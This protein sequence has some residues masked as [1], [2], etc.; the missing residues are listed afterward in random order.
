MKL[1]ILAGPQ[2][3]GKM[4]IGQELANITELK[5]FHNHQTIEIIRELVPLDEEGWKLVDQLREPIFRAFAKSGQYGMVYTLVCAFP[6]DLAYVELV[7]NRFREECPEGDFEFYFVELEA[8]FEERL[9][10]NKTENRLL[11]KPSKRD[12]EWSEGLLHS[13]E[14]Q[15]RQNSLPGEVTEPNYLRIDNTNLTAEEVAKQIK[16][17]FNL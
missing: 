15:Y 1:V 12:L 9:R 14:T 2:A 5:L 7:K 13:Y 11:H 17:K 4:T 3:I 10:R 16:E 6:Q 8:D